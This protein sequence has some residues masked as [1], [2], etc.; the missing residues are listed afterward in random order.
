MTDTDRMP[1]NRS[2]SELRRTAEKQPRAIPMDRRPKDRDKDQNQRIGQLAQHDGCHRTVGKHIHAKIAAQHVG[3]EQRDLHRQWP[4]KTHPCLKCRAQF[5]RGF[6]PQHGRNR[7]ARNHVDNQKQQRHRQHRDRRGQSKSTQNI[8]QHD[9]L[10]G[11]S[12]ISPGEGG[13]ANPAPSVR[14]E[15]VRPRRNSGRAAI[16]PAEAPGRLCCDRSPASPRA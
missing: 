8:A 15:S 9:F 12:R 4:V 11:C 13:Q 10:P 16:R 5:R 1:V 3:K 6:W 14:R 7:I 2:A